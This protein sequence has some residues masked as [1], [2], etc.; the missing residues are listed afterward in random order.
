M[1]ETVKTETRSK[2]SAPVEENKEKTLGVEE[3]YTLNC[4]VAERIM[5]EAMRGS[6]EWSMGQYVS[7]LKGKVVAVGKR[8]AEVSN[9]LR[10][11]E[12]DRDRGLVFEIRDPDE[13][14]RE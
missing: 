2:L 5:R 6:D 14:I 3:E 1:M 11:I 12:P 13:I 4:E 7:L 8:L 9:A 10:C